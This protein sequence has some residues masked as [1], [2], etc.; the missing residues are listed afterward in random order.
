M[1]ILNGPEMEAV[2]RGD[3]GVTVTIGVGIIAG[4]E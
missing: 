4:E 2:V 1:T 3:P